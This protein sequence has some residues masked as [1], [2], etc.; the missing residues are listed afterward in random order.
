MIPITKDLSA[1]AAKIEDPETKRKNPRELHSLSDRFD[2]REIRMHDI[3]HIC[4]SLLL[5]NVASS[6]YVKHR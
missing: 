1:E 3:R 4:A 5:S 6:V 2:P